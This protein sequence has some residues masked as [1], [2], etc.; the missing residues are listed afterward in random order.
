MSELAPTGFAFTGPGA[1]A[2][3]PTPRTLGS[4][5]A[6]CSDASGSPGLA[7]AEALSGA[8]VEVGATPAWTGQFVG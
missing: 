4:T 6:C 1:V 7:A 3:L 2:P 8:G 5:G